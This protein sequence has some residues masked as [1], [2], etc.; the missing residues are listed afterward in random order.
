[1]HA[2]HAC[3]AAPQRVCA[4]LTPRRRA[5]FQGYPNLRSAELERR[6]DREGMALQGLPDQLA[7][8]LDLAVQAA[9]ERG[10]V[11][12]GG[13]PGDHSV[14]AADDAVALGLETVGE[15]AR[16]AVVGRPEAD[17][18]RRVALGEH[19]RVGIRLGGLV[20]PAL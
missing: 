4:G 17:L 11:L 19:L 2:A 3:G 15:L 18:P 20:V 12:A 13:A 14:P 1:M 16:G 5:H 6:D 7:A 8:G 10:R 9:G